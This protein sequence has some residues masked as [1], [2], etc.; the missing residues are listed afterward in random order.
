MLPPHGS[1]RQPCH[2]NATNLAQLIYGSVVLHRQRMLTSGK[3]SLKSTVGSTERGDI[4]LSAS[5]SA[6]HDRTFLPNYSCKE[7]PGSQQVVELDGVEIAELDPA[8]ISSELPSHG[9]TKMYEKL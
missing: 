5:E 6:E 8:N 2:H 9:R 4:H 3:Q 1:Y 7:N